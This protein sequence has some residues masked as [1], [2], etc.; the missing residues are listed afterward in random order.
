MSKQRI[1]FSVFKIGL[2]AV[3]LVLFN[4]NSILG[5]TTS[6][7]G[8]DVSFIE[9]RTDNKSNDIFSNVL[10]I[11]N[12]TPNSIPFS[13]R[14]SIPDGWSTVS[15][16]ASNYIVQPNDSLFIPVNLVPRKLIMGNV[17]HIVNASLVSENQLQF[18]SATWYMNI[19]KESKWIAALPKNKIFFLDDIDTAGFSLR[20]Q[21]VGNSIENIKIT[22]NP[23]NRIRVFDDI[24]T[25][26][27]LEYYNITLP[28]NSDTLINFRVE[29]RSSLQNV[30]R[31]DFENIGYSEN[32]SYP[33]RIVVQNQP[34]ENAAVKTWRAT[35]D[36]VK[37][38]NEAKLN[39]YKTSSL[40]L[41]IEA[42]VDDLL[43]NSTVLNLS[44]YGNAY[45]EKDRSLTYRYQSFFVS[46]FYNYSP[47]LGNSHYVGYFSP[48]SSIEIGD[49]SGT[50][51]LGFSPSGRGI[52][53]SYQLNQ[54]HKVG[55][56]YLK[57]PEFFN[58]STKRDY[59]F[60]YEY[61]R[62]R[63]SFENSILLSE[64]L[65][66]NTSGKQYSNKIRLVFPRNQTLG[67]STSFSNEVFNNPSTPLSRNGF[68]YYANYAASYKKL[69]IALTNSFG[70]DYNLGY[71]GI[72]TAGVDFQY[73][74]NAS[75][76][77]N[78]T[79]Y[80]YDQS[81]KY[82]SPAGVLLSSRESS[83]ERYEL[84][85][86]HNQRDY[87]MSVK[88]QHLYNE[89]YNLRLESNGLG[90][91]FRP[92]LPNNVRFFLSVYGGYNKLLD[93]N[94][95]PYF[96]SQVR[97]T[98]RYKGLSSNIRY[99]YGPYQI[100]EQLLFATSKINNQSLYTN[101]NLR[102]WVVKDVLTFEPGLT[103]S[104]ETLYQRNRV[105]FRPEFYYL[106]KKGLEIR[107]YGQYMNNSQ[108]SNPFISL[109]EFSNNPY[110]AFTSSNL[111]FGFGIKKRI[112]VPVS[113]KKYHN[114]SVSVFKDLNGNGKQDKNELGLKDILVN[115]KTLS[116]DTS[117]NYYSGIKENGENFITN[118]LGKISYKNI[119]KGTYL[120][121]IIPLTEN[122]GF[123]AGDE[124]LV[125]MDGDKAVPMPLNQGVQLT[126]GLLVERD[127][128]SANFGGNFNLSAIRVTATDSL[129][130]SYSSLTD[131]NGRF[132]M[133]LP[134][135]VY[136]LGI[137]EQGLPDNFELAQKLLTIEMITVSDNYNVAFYIKERK[138]KVN[139]KKF[140]SGGNVIENN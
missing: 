100:Y 137:N 85:F 115:I 7:K 26:T 98:L 68:A 121:K 78:S 4:I 92:R 41:T 91:D 30:Y 113:S 104:Y 75:N 69:G 103:Y 135:G 53:S 36:F 14:I 86:N 95:D 6:Q 64:N 126:G 99:F 29:K 108:K 28:I 54:R 38:Q 48:K 109:D 25:I 57:N 27:P 35:I 2:A 39:E 97:T 96:S 139:I 50:G 40:P 32:E 102:L 43:E 112:G 89:S 62:G 13:F 107:F 17:S 101:T 8:V 140:D 93:Y 132:S 114:L 12:N 34:S 42:N 94:I 19:Q 74:I 110:Q 49:V 47:F 81:P 87:S 127:E 10:R 63:N 118:E 51:G 23:D 22:F 128:A 1:V 66:F 71:R 24:S 133:K 70:S 125:N 106:P 117:Q 105:S 3:I 83:S 123:F 45:F 59:G 82:F 79:V 90:V 124:M 15:K 131:Q 44:M 5:Q 76:S 21:N 138:R 33:L 73:R 65:L 11:K 55:A 16:R 56:F 18:A 60:S 77:I 37:T 120:V 119:P 130:K 84:R 111:Y 58:K 116:K 134:A 67:I 72:K 46:N 122:I 9:K 129:G 88:L 31:E 61:E 80:F 20:L 136:Q 52:K